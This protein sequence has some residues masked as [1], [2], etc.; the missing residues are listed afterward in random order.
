MLTFLLAIEDETTRSKLEEIYLTYHEKMFAIAKNILRDSHEAE[1]MVQEAIL[2]ISNHIE[3]INEINC[4]KTGCLVVTIVRNLCFD[5]YN[6]RKRVIWMDNE[7]ME[8]RMNDNVNLIEKH[9]IDFDRSREL[10]KQLKRI[11]ESYADVIMLRYYH[12][13]MPAEIAGLLGIKESNVY[14]RLSRARAALK[15]VIERDGA[16]YE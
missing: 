14:A 10:A 11:N 12:E 15:E 8:H 5:T 16:R 13:F 2:R 7:E 3:K 9:M 4:K 6:R 1:D